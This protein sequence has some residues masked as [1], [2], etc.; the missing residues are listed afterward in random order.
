M[1]QGMTTFPTIDPRGLFGTPG[2]NGSPGIGTHLHSAIEAYHAS[3]ARKGKRLA[4]E[5]GR[6]LGK[7]AWDQAHE[8]ATNRLLKQLYKHTRHQTPSRDRT[9]SKAKRAG[10]RKGN[11]RHTTLRDRG[12]EADWNKCPY[13]T[14][15]YAHNH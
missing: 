6:R 14:A 4:L 9:T 2:R 1:M 5:T 12:W 15:C 10:S 13:T 7:S 3:E 11:G 8:D